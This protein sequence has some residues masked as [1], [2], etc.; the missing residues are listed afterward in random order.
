MSHLLVCVCST[1]FFVLLVG[2][3]SQGNATN[4]VSFCFL[5]PRQSRERCTLKERIVSRGQANRSAR[6]WFLQTYVGPRSTVLRAMEF[7]KVCQ[8]LF[9]MFARI[10]LVGIGAI[11]HKRKA[12]RFSC[13]RLT[14]ASEN[15][16]CNLSDLP[17]TY[18]S[19]LRYLCSL[20]QSVVVVLTTSSFS[21]CRSLSQIFSGPVAIALRVAQSVV[22]RG[23]PLL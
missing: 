19:S 9:R 1:L 22:I 11:V 15:A 12:L 6:V 17:Q 7:E 8:L 21:L 16:L 20:S 3:L 4:W 2:F 10:S 14:G 23:F 5:A 13:C 18:L